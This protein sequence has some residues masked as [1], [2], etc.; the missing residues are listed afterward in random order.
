MKADGRVDRDKAADLITLLEA[1]DHVVQRCVS[2]SI[3]IIGEKD[4][5]VLNEMFHCHQSLPD[6]APSSRVYKR[7]PPIRRKL[8]QD[9]HLLT[10]IRDNAV[11]VGGLLVVKEIILDDVCL[12]AEAK[13]EILVAVIAVILHNVPQYG[14]VS[15][16]HHRLWNILGIFPHTGAEAAAKQHNLHDAGSRGS[17]TSTVGIGTTNLQ[18]QSPT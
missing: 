17:I 15:N 4:L 10:E 6:I 3:A 9:L 5:I 8:T 12:V 18:P 7:N 1:I 11:A 2:Q 14:V 13:D 16:S